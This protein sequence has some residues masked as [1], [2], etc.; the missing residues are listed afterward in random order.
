MKW[1]IT[2]YSQNVIDAVERL[3][4]SIKAKYLAIADTMI[5]EGPNLGMPF[6][7][8][9]GKGLFE[10]RAKGQLWYRQRILLYD[11]RKYNC[12]TA[13]FC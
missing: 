13:C 6:T 11:I 2:Y 3:E 5:E 9:L 12:N 10:I 4:K 7:K 8:A 1:K